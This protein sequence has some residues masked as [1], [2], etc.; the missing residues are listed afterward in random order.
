MADLDGRPI[1]YRPAD[2]RSTERLFWAGCI[3]ANCLMTVYTRNVSSLVQLWI[4]MVAAHEVCALSMSWNASCSCSCK[5][6]MCGCALLGDVRCE[7]YSARCL[8]ACILVCCP[9][10][11][12]S[13][14]Y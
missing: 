14:G 7:M 10:S 4:R 1:M 9:D 11:G 5:T 12:R 13:R 2:G 6:D 3:V 8:V